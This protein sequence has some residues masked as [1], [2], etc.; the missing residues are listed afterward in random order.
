MTQGL[1]SFYLSHLTCSNQA[2]CNSQEVK[3][4]ACVQLLLTPEHG[5]GPQCPLLAPKS[6]VD[7]LTLILH[8]HKEKAQLWETVW[9]NCEQEFNIHYNIPRQTDCFYVFLLFSTLFSVFY[10]L[11]PLIFSIF[12]GAVI[13]V[14]VRWGCLMEGNCCEQQGRSLYSHLPASSP[15]LQQE[16]R[17]HT[18][19]NCIQVVH[20][21]LFHS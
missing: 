12:S 1:Q 14:K 3:G 10:C 16:Q 19:H 7:P 15:T 4:K 8:I 21:L 11:L 9:M 6:P 18:D 13:Y 5:L 2:R 20:S 17:L